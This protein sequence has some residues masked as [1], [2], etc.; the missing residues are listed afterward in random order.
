M[1][2][3]EITAGDGTAEAYRT[4]E[5]GRPGILLI[6]DVNGI[7]PRI[8]EMADRIAGWG[9]TVLVPNLF[10]RLGSVA[11]IAPTTDLTVPENRQAHGEK[12]MFR[13]ADLNPTKQRA[14][15]AGYLDALQ[16]IA[17]PGPVGVI[18]YCMGAAMASRAAGWFPDRIAACAAFHGA[19]LVSDDP[20]SAHTVIA[21]ATA[22][23]LYGHADQDRI[24]PAEDI[25]ILEQALTDAG[26]TWISNI[27]PDAPHGFTMKD[28]VS[29]QEAGAERHF[30]E[31][32]DLFARTL[33]R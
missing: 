18:G 13:V 9:Y 23:F 20:D 27:Y 7:R 25:A 3:I 4:G 29:Y 33:G 1:A 14:D 19:R 30:T 2:L 21:S 16:A 6:T 31:S 5:D 8:E 32:K 11:E 22:E 28:L 17:A 26:L 15:L 24:N 10:Y 12:V